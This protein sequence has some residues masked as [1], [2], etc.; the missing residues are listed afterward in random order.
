MFTP[1]AAGTTGDDI[2]Q[3]DNTQVKNDELHIPPI[4]YEDL[5]RAIERNKPSVNQDQLGEY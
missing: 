4:S 3:M 5:V 2:V 1:V